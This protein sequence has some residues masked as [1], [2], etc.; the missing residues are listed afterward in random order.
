MEAKGARVEVRGPFLGTFELASFARELERM[1]RALSGR[2]DLTGTEVELKAVLEMDRLGRLQLVVD[3][4]PDQF[5]QQHRFEADL[6]QSYLPSLIASCRS[7]LE[8]F[9][10]IGSPDPV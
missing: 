5:T 3:I 9:P 8:R 1:D 7:T 6:D 2:A 10:V 4:T